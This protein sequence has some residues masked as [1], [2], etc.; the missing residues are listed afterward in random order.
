[1]V[2]GGSIVSQFVV[3]FVTEVFTVT[4]HG[5][6]ICNYL[7]ICHYTPAFVIKTS[8]GVSKT[9]ATHWP[10]IRLAAQIYEKTHDGRKCAMIV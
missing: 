6:Q 9:H 3:D 1:M 7:R 4:L 5:F 10:W 8:A 2:S